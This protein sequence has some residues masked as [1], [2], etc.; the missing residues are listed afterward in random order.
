MCFFFFFFINIFFFLLLFFLFSY[1]Q[2]ST[3]VLV[4]VKAEIGEPDLQKPNAG[5]I[6][7]SV[8]L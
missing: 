2:G 5:R 7:V 8:D 1:T 3:D 6:E 4:G